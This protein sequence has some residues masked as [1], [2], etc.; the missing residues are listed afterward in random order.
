MILYELYDHYPLPVF[1]DTYSGPLLLA[2]ADNTS[3]SSV[4]FTNYLGAERAELDYR[5]VTLSLYLIISCYLQS[6][7]CEEFMLRLLRIKGLRVFGTNTTRHGS[8]ESDKLSG[9][10]E[11]SHTTDNT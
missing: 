11:L 7:K 6:I 5:S 2:A 1:S 10:R 9:S 3:P 4:V 8:L